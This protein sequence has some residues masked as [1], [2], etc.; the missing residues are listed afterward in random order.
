MSYPLILK[1][2]R[3]VGSLKMKSRICSLWRPLNRP[4]TILLSQDVKSIGNNRWLCKFEEDK[5]KVTDRWGWRWSHA[6]VLSLLSSPWLNFLKSVFSKEILLY[7][8]KKY[9]CQKRN[10]AETFRSASSLFFWS[11][12]GVY[13][14][15][16]SP[17]VMRC[18]F[19]LPRISHSGHCEGGGY[20]PQTVGWLGDLEGPLS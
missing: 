7:F 17:I 14:I 16:V 6:L 13:C 9:F 15:F 20:R 5:V 1:L 11:S 8:Q 18:Y 12:S 10:N 3:I 19:A 2:P 4:R